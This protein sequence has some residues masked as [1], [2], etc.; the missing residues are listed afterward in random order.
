MRWK[1]TLIDDLKKSPT[2]KTK[3]NCL[4]AD[5]AAILKREKAK[6]DSV[7]NFG[8]DLTSPRNRKRGILPDFGGRRFGEGKRGS[9]GGSTS[10]FLL[11]GS[12]ESGCREGMK[13]G[14]GTPTDPVSQRH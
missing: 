10:G 8:K 3:S 7:R 6:R 5:R 9:W 1:G 14:L 11:G 2:K 13:L 4:E 12:L